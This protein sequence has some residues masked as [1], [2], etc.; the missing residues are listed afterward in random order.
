MASYQCQAIA[1]VKFL[2]ST[3][4][5]GQIEEPNAMMEIHVPKYGILGNPV[6][7]RVTPMTVVEA[8]RLGI[9]NFTRPAD[10]DV[11]PS[12][13]GKFNKCMVYC[14]K[15]VPIHWMNYWTGQNSS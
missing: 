4:D 14:K 15:G 1:G 12:I 6:V 5:F 2:L 11:S 3:C 7:F 13:A 10:D 9:M 8:E